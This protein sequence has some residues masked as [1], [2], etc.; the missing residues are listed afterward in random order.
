[1]DPNQPG[2][3]YFSQT[4]NTP[5]NVVNPGS[6]QPNNL[7]VVPAGA[8][9][10]TQ[11]Q[12]MATPPG[13]SNVPSNPAITPQN[14]GSGSQSYQD[15]FRGMYGSAETMPPGWK[16]PGTPDVP[17]PDMSRIS[18]AYDAMRSSL[19][20]LRGDYGRSYE[21]GKQVAQ[22]TLDNQNTQ[23]DTTKQQQQNQT[24]N[25]ISSLYQNLLSNQAQNRGVARAFGGYSSGFEQGNT[26][27]QQGYATNQAGLSNDLGT[28]LQQLDLAKVTAQQDFSTA[29]KRANDEY[30]AGLNQIAL[31]ERQTDLQK[32]QS[33]QQAQSEFQNKVYQAQE[34]QKAFER[35]MAALKY[36]TEAYKSMYGG[37]TQNFNP[38]SQVS[39]L[40]GLG[41]AGST[42]ST[43][44][45]GGLYDKNQ[46][47][48]GLDYTKKTGF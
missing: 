4:W 43:G 40:G 1:M 12:A 24:N 34:S 8:P 20:A 23:I 28:R 31:N 47:A 14:P 38:L 46:A 33:F 37:A 45:S 15:I 35:Q 16:P 29:M 11:N 39:S 22:N 3:G 41:M 48:G 19:D 2:G 42:G 18:A 44:V 27:L 17:N 9:V 36:Q 13:V 21:T 26:R 6:P 30:L 5:G 25:A 7:P 32:A 10:Y